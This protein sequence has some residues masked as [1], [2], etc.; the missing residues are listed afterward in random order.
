MANRDFSRASFENRSFV[1]IDFSRSNF[2]RSI[3]VNV[4]FRDCNLYSIRSVGSSYIDSRFTGTNAQYGTFFVCVDFSRSV[5]DGANFAGCH[6]TEANFTGVQFGDADFT[7]A[8]FSGKCDFSGSVATEETK[9]DNVSIER[10]LASN[11]IFNNYR[12][13][14]GILYRK[15]PDKDKRDGAQAPILENQLR[16][17]VEDAI[18][19][20][21]DILILE[22]KISLDLGIGHNSG[23]LWS[24][25]LTVESAEIKNVLSNLREKMEPG[26]SG[27]V[28]IANCEQEEIDS[29]RSRIAEW[30]R[31]KFDKFSDSFIEELGKSAAD[32]KI[33]VGLWAVLSGKLELIATL[34][35]RSLSAIQ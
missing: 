12:I 32:W 8:S 3:F 35:L 4:D 33:Y 14:R 27:V 15:N 6:F 19:T 5:F 34:I 10:S 1:G 20:T 24:T 25:A 18:R 9:F 30:L 7:G 22:N 11:E 16:F 23:T 29:L 21:N 2:D 31:G 28:A 26:G 13:S 17:A